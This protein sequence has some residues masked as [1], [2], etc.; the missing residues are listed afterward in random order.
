MQFNCPTVCPLDLLS[1]HSSRTMRCWRETCR[2]R[3]DLI[4]LSGLCL[5][6]KLYSWQAVRS[7]NHPHLS[8]QPCGFQS[9]FQQAACSWRS[10]QHLF[11][12][13]E[14]S[15]FLGKL[16]RNCCSVLLI[17]APQAH[18]CKEDYLGLCK[19]GTSSE[20]CILE[21]PTNAT[22]LVQLAVSCSRHAR[23]PTSESFWRLCW[24]RAVQN[25]RAGPEDSNWRRLLGCS[26]CRRS[27]GRH[28][29]RLQRTS[30]FCHR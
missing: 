25:W 3:H 20:F 19:G 26:D 5:F 22:H 8:H 1:R 10:L 7:C 30:V 13:L 11:N 28:R 29:G 2:T 27:K 6:L 14:T 12:S 15:L 24:L 4:C 16:L 23:Q 17:S 21:A 9:S 18:A